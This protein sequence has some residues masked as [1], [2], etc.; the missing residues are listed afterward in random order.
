M[1][2]RHVAALIL[3]TI[4]VVSN[5]GKVGGR[6]PILMWCGQ[7]AAAISRRRRILLIKLLSHECLV[8][9]RT[10]L[11]TVFLGFTSFV[12]LEFQSPDYLSQLLLTYGRPSDKPCDHNRPHRHRNNYIPL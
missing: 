1:F 11:S 10:Y 4:V 5:S 9:P 8:S 12:Y 6:A 3:I 2:G 7:A